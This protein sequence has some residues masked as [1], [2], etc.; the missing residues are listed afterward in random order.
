MVPKIKWS[1]LAVKSYVDN[2]G[3]L[4]KEWSQKEVDHFIKAVQRKIFSLSLQPLSA[5]ITNKRRNLRKTVINKRIILIYRYKSRSNEIELVRFFN[6]Y[7][8]PLD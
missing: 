4:E 3:Y 1:A 7:Q 2:I 8:H 5:S 6:T